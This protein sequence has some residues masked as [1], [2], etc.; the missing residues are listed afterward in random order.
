MKAKDPIDDL[1]DQFEKSLQLSQ[2]SDVD[3][4][5]IVILSIGILVC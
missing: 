4:S 3:D 5:D 2:Q 1:A